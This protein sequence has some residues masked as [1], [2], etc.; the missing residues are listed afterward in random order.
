MTFFIKIAF[1]SPPTAILHSKNIHDSS[2]PLPAL[3]SYL[4]GKVILMT[5]GGL[6][7][8]RNVIIHQ[9]LQIGWT[10]HIQF[11]LL[12]PQEVHQR[13]VIHSYHCLFNGANCILYH[14][15]HQFAQSV[16]GQVCCNLVMGRMAHN[17]L[18]WGAIVPPLFW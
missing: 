14:I 15:L 9:F 7:Y 18:T 16:I 11:A 2:E 4:T 12:I 8:L 1:D 10:L 17:V 3:D 5:R 13:R 6:H